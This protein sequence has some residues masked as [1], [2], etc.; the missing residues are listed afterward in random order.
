M[1]E[2]RKLEYGDFVTARGG[3]RGDGTTKWFCN[4]ACSGYEN[5][6]RLNI[7]KMG[8]GDAGS[9]VTIPTEDRVEIWEM[10]R[11]RSKTTRKLLSLVVVIKMIVNNL[12][13]GI[14]CNTGGAWVRGSRFGSIPPQ[15]RKSG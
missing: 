1:T 7:E 5:E 10:A 12:R 8:T 3:S 14:W 11:E 2:D 9:R 6:V 15:L 13:P 4:H